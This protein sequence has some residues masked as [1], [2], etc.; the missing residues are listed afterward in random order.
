MFSQF[1]VRGAWLPLAALILIAVASP[2]LAAQPA[3]AAKLDRFT[4]P[5]GTNYY[6]LSLM[7]TGVAP[8]AGPRDVVVLFD[9]SAGQTGDFRTAALAVLRGLIAGL[10]PNDRVELMAVDTRPV[11]L[12]G[13]LVTVGS[14]ELA[15]AVRRLEARVPLGATDMDAALTAAAGAVANAG[16]N[17]AAVYIGKGTSRA[18]LISP[19][20]FKTLTKQLVDSRLPVNSFVVGAQPDRMLLGALAAQTGGLLINETPVSEPNA[21]AVDTGRVV[22]AVHSTVFWPTQVALPQGIDKAYPART[23]PLRSDRETVLIGTMQAADAPLNVAM[24]VEGSTG[25]QKLSWVVP[26]AASDSRNAYLAQLVNEA[27]RDGGVTLPVTDR[28]SLLS[29]RTEQRLGVFGAVQLAQQA[30]NRGDLDGAERIAD[31]ALVANPND[32]R[33]RA[34]KADVAQRRAGNPADAAPAL[35]PAPAGAG[36]APVGVGAADLTILGPADLGGGDGRF[37]EAV[38]QERNI[39]A[40][41]IRTDVQTTVNQARGLMSTDPEGA[42]QNLK[43]MLERVR[44]SADLNPEVRNQLVRVIES[45][46]REAN[47]RAYELEIVRQQRDARLAKA[48][49]MELIGEN[50]IR[51]EQRLN[52]L[53][54]RFNSLMEEG[55]YRLAEEAAAAEAQAL[56]PDEPFAVAATITARTTAHYTDFMQLRV[57]RQKGVVDTLMQVEKSHIPLPDEPPLVYPAAD[58]WREL[59]A[60]RKEKYSSMDLQ[61][62]NPAE[63]RIES[64]LRSPTQLEFIDTPLRDVIEYLK[65]YHQIE[66]QI[67]QRALDDVA[68]TTD[69]PVTRNLKGISLKSALRLLLRELDLQYIIQDEVLLITTP[70]VADTLLITKVYPVADLVLPIRAL[71][72]SGM[73]GGMGGGGMGGMGGGGM[74]GGGMGGMGG[75]MGGGGMGG[76]MGGGG[77]GGGFFNVPQGVLP[78]A[79]PG[80]FQAFA[81]VD[82]LNLAPKSA[83]PATVNAAVTAAQPAKAQPAKV[84]RIE[85]E[86]GAGVDPDQAW[87]KYFTANEPAEAA[88]RE[89][90]RQLMRGK[91][92]DQTIALVQAA[93][94][95]NQAQPWMYEALV[96]AMQAAERPADEVERA[97]MSAVDMAQTPLDLMFIGIY[98]NQLGFDARALK[99]YE[100]VTKLAPGMPQ[101]YVYGLR[102][103]NRLG[104]MEG[105]QWATLGILSQAW[106]ADQANIWKEG[107]FAAKAALEKLRNEKMTAAAEKYE[108]ALNEAIRRDAVVRVSWTGEADIDLIVED[109]SGAVCS[110]RSPRSAGGGLLVGDS[111][112]QMGDNVSE[113]R[114]EI[115]V[116][117]AGFS[118]TYRVLVRRV[119]GK[120]T[121]GKVNVEVITHFRSGEAKRQQQSIALE[122]DEAVVAFDLADGRRTEP[123]EQVAMENAAATHLAINRQVLGQQLA[124]AADPLALVGLNQSRSYTGGG[125]GGSTQ[126]PFPF[127]GQGAVGYQPVIIWIPEGANLGAT[128]VVSADRRYVRITCVPFFSAI[129]EVNVFNMASGENTEGRGGTGGGGFSDLG[130]GNNN[131]GGGGF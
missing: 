7:P 48:Q 128:A 4:H 96:L 120:P 12:S 33:A 61:E 2:V 73:F 13:G 107:L 43:L 91:K 112:A 105:V 85:I 80:G 71:D 119:W 8:A 16:T 99:V 118:G 101:P 19:E 44:Q 89:T 66:I 56:A 106:S 9:T 116:C 95:H 31:Q 117:P 81:V 69:T 54:E 110:T 94:R 15:D 37:A 90:V 59:T 28:D 10:G 64:A 57:A 39:T 92:Y 26:P 52:Q 60:R 14:T 122:N 3:D 124:G 30:L 32:E 50:L 75:G 129:R 78:Q 35:P 68:I 38:I 114:S 79:P 40:Q 87:E 67:D 1:V 97:I 34:I 24:T 63:R 82:D 22:S 130:G 115:Y 29:A 86:L 74:G 5:D 93:L 131:N 70:E 88:V 76:G 41:V 121:A 46:L 45:T 62:R 103:A 83:A 53:M 27:S 20:R 17:R 77:M 65:D 58:V 127:F 104:D 113:G 84:D 72:M 108:K 49:E 23:P 6:A 47:R 98:L 126:T 125:S 25:E 11:S 123:L 55:H 42:I 111:G 51:R 102:T 109:P 36:P 21:S 100:D 18:N